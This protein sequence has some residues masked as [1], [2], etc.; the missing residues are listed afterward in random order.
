[1]AAKASAEDENSPGIPVTLPDLFVSFLAK[2]PKV[3]SY[4]DKI[5]TESEVWVSRSVINSRE[6]VLITRKEFNWHS[7]SAISMSG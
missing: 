2:K 4:Y 3:N 7:A 6:H 1:M 5:R